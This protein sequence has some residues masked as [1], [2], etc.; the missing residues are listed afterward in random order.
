MI[1]VDNSEPQEIVNLLSQ[2]VQVLKGSL[3]QQKQSD[4]WFVDCEGKSEQYSRKQAGELLANI[5]EAESQLRDYYP[6]ADRNY[7]LV[8]GII[9][10][11][12]LTAR[13][14]QNISIRH[15][16]KPDVLYTYQVTANGYIF[17]ERVYKTSY[18]MYENWIY[19][20]DRSGITTYYTIDHIQT[21][22]LLVAHYNNAQKPEEE[23]GTLQ[24]ITKPRI[25][26]KSHNPFIKQLVYLS[27][28]SNLGIGETKAEAIWNFGYH[29]IIDLAMATPA[30]LCQIQGL[31]ETMAKKLLDGLG[32]E[33]DEEY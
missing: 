28:A 21:A 22:R 5:D 14:K 12:S 26:L 13:K 6:N 1:L 24:R 3:N 8:E 30:E 2:S 15:L 10:P 32:R 18:A 23:H 27:A 19:R 31:A 9:S 11:I 4:Y 16:Y 33:S 29:S 7:Q 25:Y 17:N 20:L